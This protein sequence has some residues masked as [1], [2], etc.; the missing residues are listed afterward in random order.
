MFFFFLTCFDLVIVL[1]LIGKICMY[2]CILISF[3]R[4][5]DGDQDHLFQVYTH[6]SILFR[7]QS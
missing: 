3:H 5:T 1:L 6:V 2:V 7:N 4:Q